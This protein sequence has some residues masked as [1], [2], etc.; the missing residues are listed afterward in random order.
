LRSILVLL[1]G[2]APERLRKVTIFN[3]RKY[4]AGSNNG[5]KKSASSVLADAY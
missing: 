3:G 1:T 4:R 2:K 5:Q